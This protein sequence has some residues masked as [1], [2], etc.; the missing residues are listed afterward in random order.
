LYNTLPLHVTG[1][2]KAEAFEFLL[3]VA[4]GQTGIV[5]GPMTVLFAF[6][7]TSM[8]GTAIYTM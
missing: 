7:S 3:A 5:Q 6:Y 4:E 1:I 2:V 8:I